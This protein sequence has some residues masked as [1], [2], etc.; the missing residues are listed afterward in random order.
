[1]LI[2]TL[3]MHI[4]EEGLSLPSPLKGRGRTER[5]GRKLQCHLRI[6]G[7]PVITVYARFHAGIFRYP[8]QAGVFHYLVDAPPE[9]L[10]G[11]LVRRHILLIRGNVG[12]EE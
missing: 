8:V 6:V 12:G 3:K 2:Y 11:E 1:M 4:Q 10:T 5:E 7:S 9:R